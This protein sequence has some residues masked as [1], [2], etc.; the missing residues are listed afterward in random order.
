VYAR[1]NLSPLRDKHSTDS[2]TEGLS[3]SSKGTAS[4]WEVLAESE[5]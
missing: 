1:A 4:L 3:R 5:H 2:Y